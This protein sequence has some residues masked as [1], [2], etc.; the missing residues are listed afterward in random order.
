MRDA[1]FDFY[2]FDKF[3]QN[4]F[5]QGF[6]ITP[7][8]NKSFE[9][10]TAFEVFEHLVNPIDELEELLKNSRNIL[11]S[12]ELLP[13]SNP[14]PDE[15]W[16]YVLHEGQHV[17][18]Y[19]AKALSIIADKFN[20]NFYSNGSSLHLLTEKNLPAN[21]FEQLAKGELEVV[22][23]VSLLQNDYLKAVGKITNSQ[24]SAKIQPSQIKDYTDWENGAKI[25]VDGIFFQRYQTG[26]ARLWRC[27]LK[28]WP[29]NGF[30]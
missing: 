9:L 15:W 11:L 13:E 4:I 29:A 25:I 2:W 6:E 10:V 8:D 21:L 22:K 5:A 20:L 30:A 14:K 16:Y 24:E 18:L 23:K 27:I 1:G 17:S 19:T 12:T 26:I 28:E 3:C 7:S